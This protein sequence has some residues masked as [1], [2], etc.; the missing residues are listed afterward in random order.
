MTFDPTHC[1]H[2]LSISRH[3]SHQLGMGVALLALAALAQSIMDIIMQIV[4]KPHP[5]D[6][7]KDLDLVMCL[8]KRPHKGKMAVFQRRSFCVVTG[9]SRGLGREIAIQFSREWSQS[10]KNSSII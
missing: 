2:V 8:N 4:R 6:V 3:Q 1:M 9:A 7:V 5:W 10:G